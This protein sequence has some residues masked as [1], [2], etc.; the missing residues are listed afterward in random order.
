MPMT[1]TRK[2][3]LGACAA[4]FG[5]IIFSAYLQFGQGLEPCPLCIVQRL[6]IIILALLFLG[7]TLYTPKPLFNKFYTGTIMFIA[8]FGAATAWKQVQLQKLP[9]DQVPE[10]GPS[11]EYMLDHFPLTETI[12]TVFRGTGECAEVVWRFF[13]F[14]IP[15]WTLGLF[16]GLAFIALLQFRQK[17]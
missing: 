4:C 13:G 7:G 16:L 6:L 3:S 14:S 12:K 11:L 17:K 2:F 9:S 15:Q 8:L 10:C 5:A 1:K